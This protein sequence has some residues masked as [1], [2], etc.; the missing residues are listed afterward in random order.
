MWWN[1]VTV[2]LEGGVLLDYSFLYLGDG[3]TGGEEN[4]RLKTEEIVTFF[5]AAWMLGLS[6]WNI[7]CLVRLMKRR[8]T[9][10]KI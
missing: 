5:I 2:G 8:H 9:E 6:N 7:C 4:G 1:I 10:A 3:R